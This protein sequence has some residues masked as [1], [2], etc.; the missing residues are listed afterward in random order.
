MLKEIWRGK[1]VVATNYSISFFF[2]YVA[3]IGR[4]RTSVVF[5]AVG[6]SQV[7]IIYEELDTS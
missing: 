1:R 6:V 3:V 2:S 5:Q 7:G 4:I